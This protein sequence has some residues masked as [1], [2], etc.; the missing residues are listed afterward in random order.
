VYA[1]PDL[2]PLSL[3]VAAGQVRVVRLDEMAYREASFLDERILAATGPGELTPWNALE[4]A[5]GA[6]GGESDFIFHISHV[7]STLLARLLGDSERVFCL[8]EPAILRTLATDGAAADAYLPALLK[9]YARSYHPRQ[10]SLVKT[11]SFVSEIGCSMLERSPSAQAILMFTAPMTFMT[12]LLAGPNTRAGLRDASV[13][14]VARLNAMLG[15]T[16]WV[17]AR[18]SEGE[19]A[20]MSWACE[21]LALAR[22]ARAYP[23][24]VLWLDFDAFLVKPA[25]HLATS[26]RRLHGE[27]PAALVEAMMAAPHLRRY[28]KAPEHAY[29]AGLRHRILAEGWRMHRAELLRGIGWLEAAGAAHPAIAN[30]ARLADA[31]SKIA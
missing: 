4:R 5:A 30:A 28:S 17:V 27:A 2:Y 29:D 31:G 14:R 16:G 26:L 6:L 21:M 8:R 9:L 19:L 1:T 11:T 22:I 12:T 7:G 24:R 13:Q 18:L 25:E 20:A 10:K 3:D 15:E 23:D